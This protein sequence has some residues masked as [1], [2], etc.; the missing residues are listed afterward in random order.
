MESFRQL[1]NTSSEHQSVSTNPA[2]GASAN[3]P[4]V[5]PLA[6][7]AD[8]LTSSCSTAQPGP[9][10][11]EPSSA[12]AS[13]AFSCATTSALLQTLPCVSSFAQDTRLD[14]FYDPSLQSQ[15]MMHN[16]FSAVSYGAGSKA[17]YLPVKRDALGRFVSHSSK[18]RKRRFDSRSEGAFPQSRPEGAFPQSSPEGNVGILL[19]QIQSYLS[20]QSRASIVSPSAMGHSDMASVVLNPPPNVTSGGIPCTA[21]SSSRAVMG[22]VDSIPTPPPLPHRED[23]LGGEA[24]YSDISESEQVSFR[25]SRRQDEAEADPELDPTD[26]VSSR[27]RSLLD[28]FCPDFSAPDSSDS[29]ASKSAWSDFLEFQPEHAGSSSLRT[30]ATVL[31]SVESHVGSIFP[32]EGFKSSVLLKSNAP[33]GK[34]SVCKRKCLKVRDEPLV[35]ILPTETLP[36]S[37][38]HQLLKGAARVAASSVSEASRA[39]SLL[40]GFLRM[41]SLTESPP[42]KWSFVRSVDKADLHALLVEISDS[43]CRLAKQASDIVLALQFFERESFTRSRCRDFDEDAKD[44][45]RLTHPKDFLST[46]KSLKKASGEEANSSYIRQQVSY[47]RRPAASRAPRRSTPWGGRSSDARPSSSTA[48]GSRPRVDPPTTVADRQPYRPRNR[49]KPSKHFGRSAHPQ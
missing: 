37:K 19:A 9:A 10:Q 16:N 21:T 12:V 36:G 40:N 49:G 20:S 30:N 4:R 31:K 17:S 26:S 3:Q 11:S 35:K 22:D 27:L 1:G 42:E 6:S 29:P 34:P 14:S 28:R 33:L 41:I 2:L 5:F 23:S 25:D 8:S 43:H 44:N 24:V 39:E 18:P 15:G 46:Y 38:Q 48:Y 47:N 45:L 13:L 7:L 32:A